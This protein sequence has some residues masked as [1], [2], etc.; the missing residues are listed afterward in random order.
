MTCYKLREREE[1]ETIFLPCIV[2]RSISTYD[3]F[4][5]IYI[6]IENVEYNC[7][8]YNYNKYMRRM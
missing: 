5:F 4:I 2:D 7:K 6:Y 1:K 8:N 3:L